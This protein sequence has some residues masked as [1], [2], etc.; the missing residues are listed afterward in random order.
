M[1][2]ATAPRMIRMNRNAGRRI[3][4]AAV[5]VAALLGACTSHEQR[6]WNPRSAAT[7]LDRRES[8]WANWPTAR[9]D[10]Q[11]FCVSCHTALPYALARPVLRD[12]ESPPTEGERR[13][14]ENV[15]HRV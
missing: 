10:Q 3:P 12:P 9:R 15:T 1:R 14:L 6:S 11:T 2:I 8:W 13:L 4:V 5:I 7:Y